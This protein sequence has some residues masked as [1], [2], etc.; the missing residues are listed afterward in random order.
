MLTSKRK[1]V[2]RKV[3]N[4]EVLFTNNQWRVVEG[5]IV[6]PRGR[7]PK[8]KGLFTIIGEKIPFEAVEKIKKAVTQEYGTVYGIYV[9]HD[10]MT[11]PRYIGRGDIF[12][13]LSARKK[14]HSNELYYFSF[15]VVEEKV[16]ERE[17]ETLLIH[18]T[19]TLLQFNERKKK[20]NLEAGSVLDFEVG[21]KFIQRQ[22]K[23]GRTSKKK[24]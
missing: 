12:N 9:A 10:S 20:V 16:H 3:T 8:T 17:I 6:P 23:R 19:S 13:R 7:P 11:L 22:K 18:I 1:K 24:K 21:T 14:A 5:R 15:Y 2:G 4:M